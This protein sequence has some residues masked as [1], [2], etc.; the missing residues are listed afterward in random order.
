MT[1]HTARN[2]YRDR[3]TDQRS[4]EELLRDCDILA[5]NLLW[6]HDADS[7]ARLRTFGEVVESAIDLWNAIPTQVPDQRLD[8]IHAA[9][10]ALH[11]SIASDRTWPGL[12]PPDITME[13]ISAN[14]TRAAD[15]ISS[16]RL[17]GIDLSPAGEHTAEAM[18]VRTLHILHL[19]T[20]ATMLAAQARIKDIHD[21]V[22]S[23]TLTGQAR[24]AHAQRSGH[25]IAAIEGDLA[26]LI[27][28]QWPTGINT[29]QPPDK[30][31]PTRLDTA[32]ARW[33][34]QAHR[35]LAA[36]PTL[37]TMLAI[38][39]TQADLT[40]LNLHITRAAVEDGT[41]NGDDYQTRIQPALEHLHT[42]WT[43]LQRGFAEL[44]GSHREIDPDLRL[45]MTELRAAVR[46]ISHDHANLASPHLLAQR[47][48]LEHALK[49]LQHTTSIGLNLAYLTREA[50]DTGHVTVAA[51]PALLQAMAS[52]APVPDGGWINPRDLLSNRDVTPPTPVNTRLLALN[53]NV[54]DASTS[55]DSATSTLT[56]TRPHHPPAPNTLRPSSIPITSPTASTPTSSP[57]IGR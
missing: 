19:T 20:H 17:P 26:R 42:S 10:L 49:A 14:L 30:P 8:G 46:E 54:I 36:S 5:R 21:H 6:D 57:G 12:G 18:R 33:D 29:G 39:N 28:L 3:P 27:D 9:T 52:A 7:N 40:F 15:L 37:A 2:P 23:H 53:A 22:P 16:R 35:S 1:I 38:A 11:R 45:T 32:L 48:D 34:V 25:R 24:L 44:I 31:E 41:I 55:A 13:E 47:L 56:P 43:T 51:R 4:V 50:I